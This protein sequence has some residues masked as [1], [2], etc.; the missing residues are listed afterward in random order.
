MY[1]KKVLNI[2][3]YRVKVLNIYIN[4]IYSILSNYL[5]IY[6]A[7]YYLRFQASTW[8]FGTY[9]SPNAKDGWGLLYVLLV[10]HKLKV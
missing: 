2:Y 6:R 9:L 3:T 8:A 10:L 7:W 1:K 5:S 4:N